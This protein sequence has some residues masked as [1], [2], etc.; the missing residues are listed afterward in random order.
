MTNKFNGSWINFYTEFANALLKY[1]NNRQELIRIIKKVFESVD[2]KLP[3][4]EKDNL[5]IDI[6]PFTVFALF[7]KNL[8]DLNR[9]K[10]LHK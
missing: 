2:M 1:R 5:V 7:N 9:K 3:K 6:D 8:T 10:I 4:L